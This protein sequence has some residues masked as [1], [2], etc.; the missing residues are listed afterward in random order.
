MESIR[1]QV[2]IIGDNEAESNEY[3]RCPLM[4]LDAIVQ[5]S[6]RRRFVLKKNTFANILRLET[7]ANYSLV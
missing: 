6:T 5:N 7:L 1:R 2:I 4:G 3:M